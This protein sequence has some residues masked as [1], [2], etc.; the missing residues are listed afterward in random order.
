MNPMVF[1]IPALMV[2][3]VLCLMALAARNVPQSRSA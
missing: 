1:I 2:L 3:T